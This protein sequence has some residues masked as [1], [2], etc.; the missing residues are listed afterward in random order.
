[1]YR[2]GLHVRQYLYGRLL[3]NPVYVFLAYVGILM[4]EITSDVVDDVSNRL[5]I[6]K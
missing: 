4:S 5:I 3:S 2:L 6:K 1:M